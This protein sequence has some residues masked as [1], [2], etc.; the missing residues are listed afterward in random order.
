MPVH[1]WAPFA[2]M[3]DGHAVNA[4]TVE[5]R[6]TPSNINAVFNYRNFWDGR[7]N[8]TFNGVNPFGR[9]A[10]IADPGARVYTTDGPPPP[11]KRCSSTT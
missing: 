1:A 5:R 6:N 9:R 4:R 3:V 11:R 10:I 2:I 8:N 7:A